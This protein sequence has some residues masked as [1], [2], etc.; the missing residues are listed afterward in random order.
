MITTPKKTK[1][2]AKKTRPRAA[3]DVIAADDPNSA[4]THHGPKQ[5]FH[6]QDAIVAADGP[7]SRHQFQVLLLTQLEPSP[8]N[9]RK[10]FDET[11]LEELAATIRQHGI[12]EPL[13]VRQQIDCV[14]GDG[15]ARY[16]IVCGE[17][18]YRAAKLAKLRDAPCRVV[19]LSA[20]E[21]IEIQIVENLARAD[22]N[23]I[24]EAEGFDALL[25]R[26]LTQAELAHKLGCAQG[27]ISNRV[28]LLELPPAIR[29]LISAQKLPPTHARLLVP[30]RAAPKIM[31]S[32]VQLLAAREQ[33][34]PLAEWQREVASA[35]RRATAP[36]AG[37]DWLDDGGAYT[38]WR[39]RP[40]P[41]QRAALEIVEVNDGAGAEK[42]ALNTR[43]AARLKKEVL[44]RRQPPNKQDEID[45]T[46]PTAAQKRAA[47]K[48]QAQ[49]RARELVAWRADYTRL[50]VDE[51]LTADG[52]HIRR[53]PTVMRLFLLALVGVD[54]YRG[55]FSLD[56]F[57]RERDITRRARSY[58]DDGNWDAL[59]R[60]DDEE[61]TAAACACVRQLFV[62]SAGS[63]DNTLPD[64]LVEEVGARLGVDLSGRW[65]HWSKQPI[66]R[67][68]Y[69]LI[70]A[71]HERAG[72]VELGAELN[73]VL[74]DALDAD[75]MF[76]RLATG[77]DD[78]GRPLALPQRV[79]TAQEPAR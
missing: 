26:G 77:L 34:P 60:L 32:I 33:A 55:G 69:Q 24:E 68:L 37:A 28:R 48:R 16:E 22:L 74:N 11:A 78:A 44:A 21:V 10:Y 64:E 45:A 8:T 25:A 12:I 75:A 41:A 35:A 72:L 9:P 53:G 17:R 51:L 13:V 38:S 3:Q 27:H 43:L 79:L 2:P 18:R 56:P 50:L 40:T 30:Y 54:D 19:R 73:V 49:E 31:D 52:T 62:T 20:A 23:P 71:Q 1:L 15:R 5:H 42:R 70:F 47:A 57:F 76:A 58:E 4:Y 59:Q 7:N 67:A 66:A 6:A 14:G 65:V 46:R 39:I 61:L 36:L 29:E 63:P